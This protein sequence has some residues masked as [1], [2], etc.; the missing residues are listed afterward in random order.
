MMKETTWFQAD[1][2]KALGFATH[3]TPTKAK[4]AASAAKPHL[5]ALAALGYRNIPQQLSVGAGRS[6]QIPLFEPPNSLEQGSMA[7]PKAIT[8]AL[9]LAEGTDEQTI[10]NAL[11]TILGGHRTAVGLV[12]QLEAA[13]GMT[14]E[15]A[16]G[17]TK[18]W[19]E[20][21]EKLPKVEAE[22]KAAQE[23]STKAELEA[24]I[25][26]ARTGS[27]Y[28]DKKP[29]LTKAE[30]DNL[31]E[32]ITKGEM[33]LASARGFLAVKA[34]VAHLSA[35]P[36]SSMKMESTGALSFEGREYAA[37]TGPQRAA[38]Q[39][40]DPDLFSQMREH[41]EQSGFPERS[42]ILS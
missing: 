36:S 35:S 15:E 20:S 8:A 38:L 34:P 30:A 5:K 7:I 31:Q 4:A 10:M 29:R 9:S 22:L 26:G 27:A 37:L 41:W 14:G 24:L 25:I 28:E 2:A 17:A 23:V 11:T 6:S 13:T 16:I 19:Q 21:H 42:G 40:A 39:K 3:I 33:S 18:A 12:G 1:E 32:Q